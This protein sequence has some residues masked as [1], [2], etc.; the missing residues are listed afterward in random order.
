V[1]RIV[2]PEGCKV[3]SQVDCMSRMVLQMAQDVKH[4]TN[5]NSGEGEKNIA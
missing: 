5:V 4:E 2:R 1:T 3:I